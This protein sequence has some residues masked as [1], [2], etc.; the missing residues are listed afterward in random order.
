MGLFITSVFLVWMLFWLFPSLLAG[1]KMKFR[2]LTGKRTANIF[3]HHY[4]ESK[5]FY[6][7]CFRAIPC[8]TYIDDIDISKSFSHIQSN[9]GDSIVDTYQ[10]C[11]FNRDAGR[12]EFSKTIF[13]LKSRVVIEL[14]G[15]YAKVLHPADQ[16]DFADRLLNA[17][18]D[19]RLPEKKEDFEINIITYSNSGLDLKRLDIKP[20]ALDLGMYYN[21]DFKDIDGIIRQRLNQQND[22]G[23]VLLHGLPG[24]GKTTYLRHLIGELKKK[25]LFVSPS[26]AGNLMNPEFIDL[27]IDNQN[28][29]LII[30][31]AENIMM[32]RKYNSDSSVSNLLNLSDGL[33][34]DCLSVQV[35]CTFNSSLD[36]IDSALMRKGR[37]IAKY[38]FGKLVVEKAQ[39]LSQQLGFDTVIKQP[40][41]I[42]EI[43]NQHEK[44]LAIEKMEVIGFRRQAELMN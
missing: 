3:E 35:I 4:L 19:Y 22:K 37:L 7:Y 43:A 30:E 5:A 24:T 32:D 28:S 16:Y 41:T 27:L 15:Q 21:D 6:M 38:E 9:Y 29:I 33:L 20:A 1:L 42:A 8:T 18:N 36:L 31:D 40:M 10:S 34:S 12:Q 26:V 25:V 39:R 2:T 14:A 13:V 44:A 17:L 11:Y 23:I